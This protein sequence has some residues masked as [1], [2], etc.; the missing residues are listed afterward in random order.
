MVAPLVMNQ[1][2]LVFP[3]LLILEAAA[4]AQVVL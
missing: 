1:R 4:G 2:S 3:A